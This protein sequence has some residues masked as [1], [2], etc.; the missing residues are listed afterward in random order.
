MSLY[1]SSIFRAYD[2]RGTYPYQI[3]EKVTYAAA[4]AFISVIGAKKVVIGRD[5][6]T[7][8][9]A[10]Q[11]AAIQGA[12]D[13]G[14]HVIDVG[15]ISTEMLYF[16]AATLDCDGGF[17][18]TASHNPPEWNGIKFIGKNAEPLTREGK[19]G[20][21][22]TFIES[23]KKLSSFD[24]GSVSPEN[25]LPAYTT[26]LN[27][28]I[29]PVLPELKIVANPN[30]GPNGKV[31][32][33]VIAN[34]PLEVVRLNWNEDGSFP[35]GKPDPLLPANRKEISELII[36]EGAHF[37]VA[38]D[39]DADRAFF[40]DNQGRFFHGYYITSL[41]IRHFLRHHPGEK[42]LSERRLT[43]A[44]QDAAQESGGELIL[45]KTGHGYIK[46]DMKK[47]HALFAGEMSG[48][49]YYRDFFNCDNGMITFLTML[50]VFAEEITAG[51][52]VSHLLDT[53]LEKYPISLEEMNFI[54]DKA[55]DI[56]Q[57]AA[58]LHTGAEQN[59]EDGLTV[60]YPTWHFNLRSSQNEP[61]LRLNIE[62]KSPDEL[63]QRKE[64]MLQFVTDFGA[65]LRDDS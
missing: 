34:L 23:G 64:E 13:A 9:L 29:P 15:I 54:T 22:Y 24:K 14:A 60:D 1:D 27:Q 8:G 37:G 18:I 58:E 51:R 38:W 49:Y 20:E 43:W 46:Q 28:F 39:A 48:H 59:H 11:Q 6:R 21:I 25:I 10:L 56:I 53:Y 65:T 30:F 2:V 19:L 4:Q 52:T 32:D 7:T 33:E 42:V 5:V 41:L 35:K 62:A 45:G 44:N 57:T 3:N 63:S 31:V 26:F 50:G 16:A 47:H 12:V 36:Q 61:V 40:Y 55:A 17:S